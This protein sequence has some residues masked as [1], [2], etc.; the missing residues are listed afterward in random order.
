MISVIFCIN[1]YTLKFST[2]KNTFKLFIHHLKGTYK[3]HISYDITYLFHKSDQS[4]H[5][6]NLSRSPSVCD[7]NPP[8]NF[9]DTVWSNS[10]HKTPVLDNLEEL[11][12]ILK[13]IFHLINMVCRLKDNAFLKRLCPH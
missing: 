1:K 12:D 11:F 6:H 9:G 8:D 5:H 4:A 7:N 13:Y 3:H 10:H 2:T